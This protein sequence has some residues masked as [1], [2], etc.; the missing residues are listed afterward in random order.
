MKRK[1]IFKII[2]AY[3]LML[4]ALLAL[5]FLIAEVSDATPLG[6]CWEIIGT[7]VCGAWLIIF[8]YAQIKN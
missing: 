5:L 3:L 8:S 4:S 2:K 6:N 1:E 7:F